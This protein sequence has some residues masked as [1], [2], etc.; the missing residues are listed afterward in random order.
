MAIS[1]NLNCNAIGFLFSLFCRISS[2]IVNKKSIKLRFN[3]P[4]ARVLSSHEVH[5][6]LQLDSDSSS[7]RIKFKHKTSRNQ[8]IIYSFNVFFV[9]MESSFS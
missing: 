1:N 7:H 2:C 9:F 4:Q 6:A 5:S 3:V 8:N